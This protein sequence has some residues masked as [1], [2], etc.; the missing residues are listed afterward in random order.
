M[1]PHETRFK[2]LRSHKRTDILL[3]DDSTIACN[4]EGTIYFSMGF[5]GKVIRFAL[6]N[7][8]FTPGLKHTLFHAVR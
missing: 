2:V 5:R 1:F 3:G 8:L 7:V 4:E 6:E